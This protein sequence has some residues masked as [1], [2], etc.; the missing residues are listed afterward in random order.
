[1][2]HNFFAL[3]AGAPPPVADQ[4]VQAILYGR[5]STDKQDMDRQSRMFTEYCARQNLV[6][7][8]EPICDFD[9]SGSIPFAERQGG[10]LVL[11]T[12]AELSTLNCQ[13]EVRPQ[14]STVLIT[15]EQ[16]RVGRDTLDIIQTIRHIWNAGITP[17]FIAQGGA[18]PRTPDNE[19][20]MELQASFAQL[21]RNRIRGRIQSKM[22]GKRA[23]GELCGQLPY[24]FDVEYRYQDNCVQRHAGHALTRFEREAQER[25]HGRVLSQKL[26]PN[27]EE[28]K[29]LRQMH[30]FRQ[31]G[32]GYHSIAK[33]LNAHGVPTKR[34]GE[35]M[36][37]RCRENSGRDA[38]TTR[39]SSGQ[40]N[41]GQVKNVL[42]SLTARQILTAG[43]DL[44][45]N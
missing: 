19:F 31:A 39:P 8:C 15:T 2:L 14:P 6:P 28:H 5:V 3:A 22:T 21:E 1:M 30:A 38:V 45:Q 16:D 34:A 11:K 43:P 36:K 35:T 27:A 18:L 41:C 29:W 24:G 37:L 44:H 17:H 42:E 32:W 10:K 7:L 23:A 25:L 4:P 13:A 20:K 40:W 12:I 33:Y 26:L 9:T